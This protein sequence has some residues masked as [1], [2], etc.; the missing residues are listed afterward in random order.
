M[1]TPKIEFRCEYCDTLLRV[2]SVH[3]GKWVTC[4]TCTAETLVPDISAQPVNAREESSVLWQPCQVPVSEIF[5]DTWT[6]YVENL[7]TLLGVALIDIVIYLLGLLTIVV[8]TIFTVWILVSQQVPHELAFLAGLL[9][10]VLGVIT[11]FSHM[12]CRHAKFYLKV[13][14]GEPVSVADAMRFPKESRTIL[15]V[16]FAMIVGIGLMIFFIPGVYVYWSFWPYLFVWADRQAPDRSVDAFPLAKE[17]TRRNMSTSV[18][19]SL[20]VLLGSLFAQAEIFT[21]TFAR[22][23]KA[24]AYLK[25]SGQ[26]VGVRRERD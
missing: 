12:A 15:P 19:I 25:M 6:I 1:V 16:A 26:D 14:R 11:L 21:G 20:V 24:V 4:P 5:R 7:W 23:L 10:A 13:A 9:I 8:P 22:L 3:H 18:S 2:S 17:L